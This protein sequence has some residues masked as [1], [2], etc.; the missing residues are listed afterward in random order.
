MNKFYTLVSAVLLSAC[1]WAQA[2]QSFSYQAVVRGLNNELIVSKQV[3]MKI[4]LLQGSENGAPLYVETH[5]P[6]ANTNGLVSISI[7]AGTKVVG[8]F[9]T[10]DWSKGPYFL[11]TETDLTGGT[12]YSLTAT[13]QL[14]SVPFALYAANSQPGP[15]GEKGDQ[16]IPGKDGVD[17]K[18][19]QDGKEGPQGPI[20]PKGDTGAIG[21]QGPIGLTG[22]AGKDGMDGKN[23]LD[24]KEGPQGPIGPKG[25]TGAIG[26][27]GPVG[28]S[29]SAGKDGADGKNGLDGK[30]GPQGPIGLTGPAGKDGVDGKNGTDGKDGAIGPIG[31]TGPAGKDGVDGKNGMDGKDGA[32]GPKGDV[33]AIG[34]QGLSGKDGI[35]GKNGLD[36]KEGPQGPTGKD[37][38][39]E[40]QSLRVST[41][42][43]TLYMTNANFIIIPGISSVNYDT[44]S[45]TPQP[46]AG[47]ISDLDCNSIVSS[48]SLVAGKA[49]N[50]VSSTIKYLGGNAGNYTTASFSSEG[51]EGLTATLAPGK[52]ANGD[53]VLMLTI[54]GT[55]VSVGTA[56]FN[57]VIGGKTCK[58]NRIIN[59]PTKPSDGYT[60]NVTDIDGNVYKTVQIGNQIWM[61]ENLNTSKYSDGTPILNVTNNYEW[62][63]LSTPAWCYYANDPSY[64]E[65]YGKLYNGYAV[66]SKSNGGKNVCPTGWHVATDPEW[67]S[68]VEYLGG[69]D[70]VGDKLKEA[71]DGHWNVPNT[72]ASNSSLFTALPGGNRQGWAN[73]EFENNTGWGFWYTSTEMTSSTLWMRQIQQND[74]R[75]F[76]GTHGKI[77]GFSVRCVKD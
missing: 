31:L 38:R 10:I 12:A 50:N 21:P 9:T 27:Q 32:I 71:G 15:K 56:T 76:R 6:M 70:I 17:G 49:A 5:T 40:Y 73:G 46:L 39:Y 22:L 25:D 74:S 48:G 61:A 57:L 3:A 47:I 36:G 7:G 42:G 59:D 4:S 58:L 24:G 51:V 1:L 68:L 60:E 13:S 16:G 18:N 35:D 54:S 26:P 8:D 75:I 63:Q 62:Y 11:K 77:P 2:P 14:L 55:P 45:I 43:D 34:P 19:G 28:L 37:G 41:K 44:T 66:S 29:G 72:E 53:G 52:Y 30:E 65:I 23:G 67:L 69:L 33:G 64:G 20:G